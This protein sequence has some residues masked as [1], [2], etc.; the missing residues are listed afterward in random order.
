MSRSGVLEY[1]RP[2]DYP[3]VDG[4]IR[5]SMVHP[6]TEIKRSIAYNAPEREEGIKRSSYVVREPITTLERREIVKRSG[7]DI[8]EIKISP[9]TQKVVSTKED[10]EYV[11]VQ[12]PVHK[13]SQIIERVI[14]VPVEVIKE[15]VKLFI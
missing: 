10:I 14:E 4:L 13:Q 5:R 15:K 2:A 8:P 9:P 1:S 6:E 12:V 7:K 11:S 3:I